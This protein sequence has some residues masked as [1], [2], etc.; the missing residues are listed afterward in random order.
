[1]DNTELDTEVE[2][3]LKQ[4]QGFVTLYRISS[5]EADK[6]LQLE[7]D[8][9]RRAVLGAIP[10]ENVGVREALKQAAVYAVAYHPEFF[11][12]FKTQAHNASVIMMSGGEIIGEEVMDPQKL[13]SLRNNGEAIFVGAGFVIYRERL[14]RAREEAKIILP[15]KPFPPLEEISGVDNIVSGSPSPPVDRYLKLKMGV[16]TSDPDIGT[17][18]IGI[19]TSQDKAT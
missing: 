15:A 3:R 4:I 12:S 8:A 16:S 6:I 1:M 9:E 11:T 5:K 7:T 19:T 18:I 10:A 17:V 2:K 14:R 13:R